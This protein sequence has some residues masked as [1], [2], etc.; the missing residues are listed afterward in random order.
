MSRTLSR[1][2][3]KQIGIV[4]FRFTRS[5]ALDPIPGELSAD[6]VGI[7]I[8]YREVRWIDSKGDSVGCRESNGLSSAQKPNEQDRL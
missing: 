3:L 7:K 1:L 5:Q 2:P 6:C 4:G 8:F